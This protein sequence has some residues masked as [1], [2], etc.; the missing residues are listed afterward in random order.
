[1]KEFSVVFGVCAICFQLYVLISFVVYLNKY[2]A[3][4]EEIAR[5]RRH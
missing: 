1:M 5:D 4:T 3:R 2:N